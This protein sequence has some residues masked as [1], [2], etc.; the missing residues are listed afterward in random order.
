MT[1][2]INIAANTPFG[3]KV[4]C[5]VVITSPRPRCAP[6]ISPTIAPMIANPNATWRLAMIHVSADGMPVDLRGRRIG[7]VVTLRDRTELE[8][9]LRELADVRGLAD[10]LR[11]QDHEFA[12]R[13]HVI[14]GLIELGRYEEAVQFINRSSLLQQ[15][16]AASVVGHVGDP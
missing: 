4:F 12:R 2:M 6:R 5:D 14:G 10:A 16:L 3:L 11:S 7:A 8:A 13:L 15:T 9:L 1:A